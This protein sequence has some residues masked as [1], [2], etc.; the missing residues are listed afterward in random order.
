MEKYTTEI[1][2]GPDEPDDNEV[3]IKTEFVHE[4]PEHPHKK[5]KKSLRK[6][7]GF[8]FLNIFLGVII[9][10][11]IGFVFVVGFCKLEHVE[12]EGT[13]NS[14][15]NEI[16]TAFLSGE[17]MDNAIYAFGI[18]LVKAHP[19]IPFVKNAEI[20][21][22]NKNTIL[23]SVKEDELRGVFQTKEG[24]CYF[25]SEGNISEISK[26]YVENTPIVTG[27]NLKE[28]VEYE[29]LNITGTQKTIILSSLK[30]LNEAHINVREIAFEKDGTFGYKVEQIFVDMGVS[31]D[32]REKCAR[33][34]IILPNIEGQK[35]TIHLEEW[36][37]ENNDIIFE[38][39]E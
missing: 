5:E 11:I 28:P 26:K 9:L 19:N 36:G 37:R 29:A 15:I 24:F 13:V 10:G 38:R 25:D 4:K 32:V 3:E 21:L 31:S 39:S 6:S 33:L 1:Q 8:Y 34:S 16:K 17:H 12:I 30:Y 35:G 22:K 27:I 7:L 18:N 14:D 23:I 20:R 2:I